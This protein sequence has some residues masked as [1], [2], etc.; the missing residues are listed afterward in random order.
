[1]SPLSTAASASVDCRRTDAIVHRH[2]YITSIKG[3]F[4]L[5]NYVDENAGSDVE[6]VIQ[7]DKKLRQTK[8]FM[9]AVTIIAGRRIESPNLESQQE[10]S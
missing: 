4:Y 1:M 2:H 6:E 3:S 8:T 7:W 9:M 10:I 5:D